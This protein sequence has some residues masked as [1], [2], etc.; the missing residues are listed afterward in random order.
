MLKKMPGLDKSKEDSR[1]ITTIQ[2]RGGKEKTPNSNGAQVRDL[3]SELKETGSQIDI[4]RYCITQGTTSY[5]PTTNSAQYGASQNAAWQQHGSRSDSIKKKIAAFTP[6]YW[7][8]LWIPWISW[9]GQLWT[10]GLPRLP[11]IILL[12]VTKTGFCMRQDVF[13]KVLKT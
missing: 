1:S 11:T 3:I 5:P 7:Q 4:R 9:A 2:G 12:N 13:L 6:C 8:V 10:V